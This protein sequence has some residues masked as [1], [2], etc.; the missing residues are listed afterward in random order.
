MHKVRVHAHA[1]PYAVRA[2]TD[3]CPVCLRFFHLNRRV[4]H[5]LAVD[6]KECG[7]RILLHMSPHTQHPVYRPPT[8]KDKV[9]ARAKPEQGIPPARRASL[10]ASGPLPQWAVDRRH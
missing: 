8:A 1:S 6:S 3:W 2:D 4:V 7:R 10:R 9:R 5:H